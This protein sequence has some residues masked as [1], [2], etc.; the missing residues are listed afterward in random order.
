MGFILK[1]L[2]LCVGFI[3]KGL[4]LC[5]GFILKGLGLCVGFILKGLGYVCLVTR[6]VRYFDNIV[7]YDNSTIIV[8]QYV[9]LAIAI[10]VYKDC[11]RVQLRPRYE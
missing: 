1:G 4:G 9:Q 10:T 3:L 7:Y 6:P 2:G 8:M 5:V 11:N